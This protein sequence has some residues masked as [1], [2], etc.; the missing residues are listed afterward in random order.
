M[1]ATVVKITRK[2]QATIPKSIRTKFGF[3]DRALALETEEGV[4]LKPVSMIHEERGSLRQMFEGK[5]AIQILKEAR[6]DDTRREGEL[7]SIK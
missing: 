4:L 7:E 2:G 6:E 5:T 1:N 3:G